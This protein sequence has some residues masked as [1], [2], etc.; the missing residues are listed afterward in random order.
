MKTKTVEPLFQF[1]TINHYG[2]FINYGPPTRTAEWCNKRRDG[3]GFEGQ[4]YRFV[5]VS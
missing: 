3:A 4:H 2:S 1:Q 5:R